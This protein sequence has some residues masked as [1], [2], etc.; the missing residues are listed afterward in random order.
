MVANGATRFDQ[1][2]LNAALEHTGGRRVEAA[3]LLGVGR[4]TV[5]R[6]L[7]PGRKRP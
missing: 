6:K 1:A 7:G 5:T 2:L 3:A 4:N